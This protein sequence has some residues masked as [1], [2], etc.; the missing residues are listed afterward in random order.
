M[1]MPI[2][3]DN[4]QPIT[5]A[6]TPQPAAPTKTDPNDPTSFAATLKTAT[7]AAAEPAQGVKAAFETH[8]AP[9]VHHAHPAGAPPDR[10]AD[11]AVEQVPGH[12]GKILDG[13]DKGMYINE[14]ANER[15]GEAFRLE[16][17]DGRWLH[18][19]GTGDQAVTEV[20]D[21]PPTAGQ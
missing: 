7:E 15:Q 12:E 13:K 20:V 21:A 18:V 17:H 8:P 16:H 14:A 19:Y 6:T 3:F 5:P 4:L 1:S 11:V 2:S 10:P 9:Q